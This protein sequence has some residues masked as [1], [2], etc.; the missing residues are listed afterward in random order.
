[1]Q[2]LLRRS[3]SD[4]FREGWLMEEAWVGERGIGGGKGGVGGV[5]RLGIG[6]AA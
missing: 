3:W 1:M 5:W 4:G 2:R 6:F